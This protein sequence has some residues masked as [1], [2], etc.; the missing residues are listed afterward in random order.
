[1]KAKPIIIILIILILA[2]AG[3]QLWKNH[4]N[5]AAEQPAAGNNANEDNPYDLPDTSENAELAELTTNQAIALVKEHKNECH[6]D[7]DSG[8]A[9]EYKYVLIVEPAGEQS[10][11]YFVSKRTF[12]ALL[13]LGLFA[14]YN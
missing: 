9:P 4:K 13:E 6:L 1:M 11:G 14:T 12:D 7:S 2:I 5:K 3:W 10:K 8:D